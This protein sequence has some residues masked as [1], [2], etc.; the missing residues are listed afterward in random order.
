MKL[1]RTFDILAIGDIPDVSY[2][3]PTMHWK[4]VFGSS[5]CQ[6]DNAHIIPFLATSDNPKLQYSTPFFILHLSQTNVSSRNMYRIYLG[7]IHIDNFSDTGKEHNY[8][9]EI[10]LWNF[11]KKKVFKNYICHFR[12][13]RQHHS[14]HRHTAQ[15]TDLKDDARLSH[16]DYSLVRSTTK[17]T[18]SLF[19]CRQPT[20]V[21]IQLFLLNP[22][23]CPLHPYSHCYNYYSRCNYHF[24]MNM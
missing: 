20:C 15:Q 9:L 14:V 13:T 10:L 16:K 5:L 6:C 24:P 19:Q 12:T 23:T 1:F 21:T 4:Y 8:K 18:N 22:L 3:H 7:H 2:I 11:T 17:M